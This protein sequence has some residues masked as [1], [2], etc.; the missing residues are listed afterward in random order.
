M[1]LKKLLLSLIILS[2]ILIVGFMMDGALNLKGAEEDVALEELLSMK[3]EAQMSY[4]ID[5]NKIF[6]IKNASG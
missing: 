2:G 5:K 4:E 3:R 1:S 6:I